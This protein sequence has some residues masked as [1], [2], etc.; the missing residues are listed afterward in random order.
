MS[1]TS[2]K[3]LA[4][5]VFLSA[6]PHAAGA[7]PQAQAIDLAPHRA[8]YDMSLHNAAAGSNVSEIRGRL[9][10]DFEGSRCAGYS[11][12]SRL[13]T[14]IFDRDGNSTVNDLRSSTFENGGGEKFRFDSSQYIDQRLSEKIAG[15]AAQRK[16]TEAID[17]TIEKP[18]RRRM[19]LKGPAL[20]PTQ[21][22]LAILNAARQGYGV[23]Q[24]NVY[25]GSEQGN[26]V[27]Q[28]TT[29]IGKPTPPGVERGLSR[30][31]HAK[32]LQDLVSWPVSIS[33]YEPVKNPAGD[34]GLPSYEL[35]FRLYSNGVS[36]DLLINYGGFSI[37][38]D[39]TRIDF[40]APAKCPAGAQ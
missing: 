22:S 4:G 39:L 30:V 13:V 6:L 28:T 12:K 17:V 23:L 24:A 34:E 2:K 8:I 19:K 27:L 29:F 26:K 5:L 3:F 10:F 35:S 33:Y 1:R 38:G 7:V 15:E 25:D 40:H 9:V 16:K 36:E 31:G 20:F 32:R 14:E 37:T 21:H 11:L 18:A